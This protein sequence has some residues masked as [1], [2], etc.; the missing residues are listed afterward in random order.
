MP[1]ELQQ[2]CARNGIE[3]K[4]PPPYAPESNGIAESLVHFQWTRARVLLLSSNLPEPLWGEAIVHVNWFLNRS[5]SSRLNGYIP[6]LA[7][8][9]KVEER[10]QV[11]TSVIWTG[12]SFIYRP[13]NIKRRKLLPRSEISC[14]VGVDSDSSLLHVFIPVKNDIFIMRRSE[15]HEVKDKHLPSFQNFIDGLSLQHHIDTNAEN[16]TESD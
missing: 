4:P 15:F 9:S 14:F 5:P 10:L 2:Y 13:H 12:V 3:I 7:M 8:E 1:T 16:E 6:I 11:S